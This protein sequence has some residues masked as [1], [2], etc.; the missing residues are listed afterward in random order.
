MQ[1]NGA[2][3]MRLACCEAT[4]A[5]LVICAPIHDALLLEAPAENIDEQIQ[6]LKLIMQHA[7]E[8]VLGAGRVCGVDVEKV[9]YPDRYSDK[10]GK[11][12]W[13]QVMGILAEC[14]PGGNSR[15]TPAETVGPVLS[16]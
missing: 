11:M 3:M 5:G 8:L 6:S 4:E 9:V 16:N 1:S 7:S 10:R 14:N 13:E 2:E 15:G 12:M